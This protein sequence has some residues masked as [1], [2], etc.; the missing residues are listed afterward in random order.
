MTLPSGPGRRM[1]D[2]TPRVARSL[3]E[4]RLYIELQ[5][6]QTCGRTE[7]VAEGGP[8]FGELDGHPVFWL[9]AVCGNCTQRERFVFRAPERLTTAAP[10]FR[11]FQGFGGP[12]SSELIDPGEWLVLADLL[13][14]QLPEPDQLAVDELTP[15]QRGQLREQVDFAAAAIV[16]VLKF[17]PDGRDEVPDYSFRT[18]QGR[19]TYHQQPWSFTRAALRLQL[20]RY[21]RLLAA[22]GGGR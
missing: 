13:T 20:D 19:A 14:A 11:R 22:L 1:R 8:E 16:E 21:E 17:I 7:L 18:P 6:C 2:G 10:G 5:R 3:D 12:A 15:E 4:A 9:E